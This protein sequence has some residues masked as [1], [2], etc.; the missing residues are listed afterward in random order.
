VNR[1]RRVFTRE[2]HGGLWNCDAGVAT[3]AAEHRV[4]I[5]AGRG[6]R[7]ARL[8]RFLE[9]RRPAGFV[10][11]RRLNLTTCCRG[12]GR[13]G[14]SQRMER[15]FPSDGE[16]SEAWTNQHHNENNMGCSR[17]GDSAA[18]RVTST[19]PDESLG[20]NRS[21]EIRGR[22]NRPSLI[23]FHQPGSPGEETGNRRR[24]KVG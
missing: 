14:R 18:G 23:K 6:G 8:T 1:H 20:L 12:F 17:K 2:F 3:I 7:A 5:R 4:G 13:E 22:A 10:G 15:D 11:S 19:R 9:H 21:L 24:P 16:D